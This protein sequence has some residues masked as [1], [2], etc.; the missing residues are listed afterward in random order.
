MSK[1]VREMEVHR[2]AREARLEDQNNEAKRLANCFQEQ[3]MDSCPSCKAAF[4]DFDGCNSLTCATCN[5]KFCSLCLHPGECKQ[6]GHSY[7]HNQYLMERE[8]RVALKFSAFV[9]H[10]FNGWMDSRL[11]RLFASQLSAIGV[12]VAA[13]A[14]MVLPS[15][16]SNPITSVDQFITT[17]CKQVWIMYDVWQCDTSTVIMQT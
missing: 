16:G 5:A 17:C 10:H 7:G 14:D 4:N 12:K 1:Q 11:F 6:H 9:K 2:T 3:M 8:K 15:A 13:V